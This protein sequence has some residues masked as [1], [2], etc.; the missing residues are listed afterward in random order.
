MYSCNYNLLKRH[1]FCEEK[2]YYL[3]QYLLN[4]NHR[5]AKILSAKNYASKIRF[6]TR[7]RGSILKK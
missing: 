5:A 1:Y 7:I 2:T 6:S 3:N 4:G